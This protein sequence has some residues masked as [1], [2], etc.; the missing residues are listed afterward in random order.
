[1]EDL[2]LNENQT[3][4]VHFQKRA[5]LVWDLAQFYCWMILTIPNFS[6]LFQPLRRLSLFLFS[7]QR[8]VIST[9]QI[10]R[11]NIEQVKR[12]SHFKYAIF[13]SKQM[14]HSHIQQPDFRHHEIHIRLAPA[15][16]QVQPIEDESYDTMMMAFY[17]L[18]DYHD[19]KR[20]RK[21]EMIKSLQRLARNCATKYEKQNR[22]KRH[23]GNNKAPPNIDQTIK[24]DTSVPNMPTMRP[25]EEIVKS[26]YITAPH[27]TEPMDI[28]KL[29]N[30]DYQTGMK[31][32]IP[33]HT[34]LQLEYTI[35]VNPPS[36]VSVTT[37]PKSIYTVSCPIVANVVT[38]HASD[39]ECL[40]FVES[41]SE[42][43]QYEFASNH[44]F[45]IP[46]NDHIGK[47]LKL[48]CTAI[49]LHDDITTINPTS[50]KA[51]G[52]TLYTKVLKG[53]S[54]PYYLTGIVHAIP[55]SDQLLSRMNEVRQQYHNIDRD[56]DA[57]ILSYNILSEGY[58]QREYSKKYMY[59]YCKTEYLET[60][61]RNQRIAIE[62]LSSKSDVILLQECDE[63]IFNE[64][65]LPLLG[66]SNY[67][68]HHMSKFSSVREGCA[69]FINNV[70]YHV[71]QYMDLPIKEILRHS[72]YL[73]PFYEI[74][75]DLRVVLEER[76]GTIAQIAIIQDRDQPDHILV[77]ANTHLFYHP[78]ASYIRLLQLHSIVQRLESIVKTI[79]TI[80]IVSDFSKEDD[81]VISS[82]QF[83]RE[84]K[85]EHSLMNAEE[86]MKSFEDEYE[87]ELKQRVKEITICSEERKD[88]GKYKISVVIG[89]DLNTTAGVVAL[90]YLE[91]GKGESIDLIKLR[92]GWHR[93]TFFRWGDEE[94]SSE[95]VDEE[96]EEINKT[97]NEQ[98]TLN[99][100]IALKEKRSEKVKVRPI[101]ELHCLE[102][103]IESGIGPLDPNLFKHSFELENT[104]KSLVYTN[105]IVGFQ[106]SL[107]YLFTS[108]DTLEVV[109]IAPMPSLSELEEEVAIPSSIFPS[110]HLSIAIDVKYKR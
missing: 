27:S 68:G 39:Y 43:N 28:S 26:T 69:T 87:R 24:P 2:P 6:L 19:M 100:V 99:E 49:R 109:R 52:V 110:D 92:N 66:Y 20:S 8:C 63:K 76:L 13:P 105:F 95:T 80:G 22:T 9:K 97:L 85:E 74:R 12:F 64:Y 34:S 73:V 5:R 81:A 98:D 107:D 67:V 45:F 38:E 96:D 103:E 18:G 72:N 32:F 25:M 31:I 106:E 47:K 60:D 57:R 16:D 54:F 65:L 11:R 91:K 55:R 21:E 93:L 83:I 41:T 79:Q 23:K 78:L 4:N 59:G 70:R 75:P 62:L 40:W 3:S 14:Q 46:T 29:T 35:I 108:K 77:V 15:M 102:K 53:R 86:R 90:D 88:V 104:T 50:D 42:P 58:C 10:T 61:Y 101:E 82:D 89:G 37:Y 56:Y 84:Q 48:F 36:I 30:E 71:I 44:K 17:M 1:M 33:L 94:E 51:D 7:T